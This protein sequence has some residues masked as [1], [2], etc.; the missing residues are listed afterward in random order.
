MKL[1]AVALIVLAATPAR[2]ADAPP[3]DAEML[4][5]LDV[6]G[7]SSY[8]R[9]RE[10]GRKLRLLERMRMLEGLRQMEAEAPPSPP[11]LVQPVSPATPAAPAAPREVK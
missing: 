6:V 4:R 8:A 10:V 11:P 9:D 1:I 7:S 3:L 5:D 2:A